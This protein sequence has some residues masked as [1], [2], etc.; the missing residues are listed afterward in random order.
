MTIKKYNII[1]V[2]GNDNSEDYSLYFPNT[3][4]Q[5]YNGKPCDTFRV[6]N[7]LLSTS[8]LVNLRDRDRNYPM[9]YVNNN[10]I[11]D[12]V[13]PDITIDPNVD[14]YSVT[15]KLKKKVDFLIFEFVNLGKIYHKLVEFK[16][17]DLEVTPIFEEQ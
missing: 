14:Y 7:C 6:D 3:R 16:D 12:Y 15:V 1:E 8:L 13:F 10:D 2:K 9:M 4:K 5:V 11:R 17:K